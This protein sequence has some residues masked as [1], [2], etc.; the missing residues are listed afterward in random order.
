MVITGEGRGEIWDDALDISRETIRGLSGFDGSF[1]VISTHLYQ[2]K[3]FAGDVSA[4]Y[5]D[6]VLKDRVL[7]LLYTLQPGWSELKMGRIIFE[8]E[9]L[10]KLL[11]KK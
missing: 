11:E 6:C 1:F 2:L 8:Q 4:Y 9:G 3:P 10:P 7:Q 5:I